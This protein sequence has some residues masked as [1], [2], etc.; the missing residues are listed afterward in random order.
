MRKFSIGCAIV[1][2]CLVGCNVQTGLAPIDTTIA[3]SSKRDFGLV[4]T[5]IPTPNPE[6]DAD[7]D[8]YQ[9]KIERDGSYTATLNDSSNKD[10][11][12]L[13]VQFRTHEI[14]EDLP[15]AIVELELK[16]GEKISYRRLAI[17]ATKDDHLYLW[18]I[19]GRKIGKHLYDDGVAAV[20]EHFT[21]STTVRC[22]SDKLLQS[23]SKHSSDIVGL[24]QVFKRQ[25]GDG[26]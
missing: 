23:L 24:V 1:L 26:R 8:S 25:P 7:V 6:F 18:M 19:D 9:M 13:I 5:W 22:D 12:K 20:I 3:D 16:N 2:L 15:H 4:G 11:E 21:F 14:S 10:D 17:A